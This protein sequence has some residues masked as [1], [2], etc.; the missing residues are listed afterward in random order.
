MNLKLDDQPREK[1]AKYGPDALTLSE[2]IALIIETGTKN[3][4]V[5]SVANRIV[6]R[7]REL[8]SVQ[9]ATIEEFQKING[10]GLAKAA[11]IVAA[12]EMGK[13]LNQ[14]EKSTTIIKTPFDAVSIVQP[15]LSFL[16]QE[17][18]HCVFLNVKNQII[19]RE[20]VFIGSLNISVVHPRE[21]FRIAL[22]LSAASLICFHNHP[23]GDPTPS[24]EDIRVTKRLANSG[25]LLGIRL[26]DH[27]IIGRN[28]HLS[29]KE[30]K[31]F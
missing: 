17:H 1:L 23:S 16:Y 12:L 9:H 15:E 29:M 22:K 25:E 6:M 4:S 19:H 28:K 24:Q 7:F 8:D 26:L 31:Y 3:E 5:L 10:I 14:N 11:K 20:T 21:V 30:K 18:F 2:L 13:R 27:I